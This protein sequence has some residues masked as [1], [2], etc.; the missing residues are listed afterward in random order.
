[1]RGKEMAK[2][3][4]GKLVALFVLINM[5]PGVSWATGDQGQ[6]FVRLPGSD[7]IFSQMNDF[8]RL[9]KAHDD[10]YN[11]ASVKEILK[12]SST[13]ALSLDQRV[14]NGVMETTKFQ[15][16]YKGVEVIGSM[17]F[18]HLG[19]I[20]TDVREKVARFDLDVRPSIEKE[21]A[22]ALAQF[23]AGNS[24]AAKT[25]ELK[26]LPEKDGSARLIYWVTL[27]QSE[28]E[29]GRDVLIDA[30]SGH[31]IAN[32]SHHQEIAPY[33]VYSAQKQGIA[34]EPEFSTLV[35]QQRLTGCKV[36][37]LATGKTTHMTA[38]ECN[39]AAA[40][41][42]QVQIDG[43]PVM[44]NPEKCKAV[45]KNSRPVGT[46]DISGK[47]AAANSKTVLSYYKTHHNRESYDNK[48]SASVS[49]VHA[50][51]KYN[52]AHW[53]SDQNIMVYGDGDGK[54]FADFSIALDVAGHEMTHGVTAHTAKLIYM[55]ESGALNEAYSDFFGVMIA[56]GNNWTI[57]KQ[58][59]LKENNGIRDLAKPE[60]LDFC[61]KYDERARKCVER[62]KYP[63]S[64]KGMMPVSSTCDRD[65]DNCWVHINSTIPGHAAYLMT[66]AIGA[67][68]TEK[69]FY[70][71]LTQNLS[72]SDDFKSMASATLQV[73]KQ[74]YDSKT[75]DQVTRVF[76]Q[77]GL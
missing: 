37:D 9:R 75:C 61:A 67:E 4:V 1:M 24:A 51:D 18:H 69:I 27:E 45:F 64:V 2:L 77:V 55:G 59:F 11:Q 13:H 46:P 40:T 25:P 33:H 31:V 35:D 52:N 42:C 49:I 43:D 73:C 74:L 53:S 22:V 8:D 7:S 60:N 66:Q 34:V 3:P 38:S 16:F 19:K 5:I 29:A 54:D 28:L 14:S 32:L 68:K 6:A 17:A 50:G 12:D 39:N 10:V 63:S 30:N 47:N 20:G 21:S 57:G 56:G 70:A 23:A 76:D 26:I 36:T 15:H 62:R 65:N 72:A 44:I 41:V 71:T 48:G 58:I